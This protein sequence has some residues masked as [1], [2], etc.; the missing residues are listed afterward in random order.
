MRVAA[1]WARCESAGLAVSFS[2]PPGAM[3]P[4]RCRGGGVWAG[5]R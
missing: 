1:W 5:R 2:A 3:V 4:R